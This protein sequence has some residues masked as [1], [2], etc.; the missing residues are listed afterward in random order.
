LTMRHGLS[1]SPEATVQ[2]HAAI[3]LI[4]PDMAAPLLAEE[5]RHRIGYAVGP[6]PLRS[7]THAAPGIESIHPIVALIVRAVLEN[8]SILMNLDEPQGVWAAQRLS[9]PERSLKGLN[10]LIR[11]RQLVPFSQFA[12][13]WE[14][15]D[16]LRQSGYPDDWV[17]GLLLITDAKKTPSVTTDD[18][19][20]YWRTLM[21]FAEIQQT[22][23]II[24]PLTK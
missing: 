1:A 12:D 2:A 11:A 4:A 18:A 22:V 17:R 7:H 19:R 13:R 20:A 8:P 9:L 14:L 16:H 10:L 21:Q 5:L 3:D 15:I 24:W 23:G 6:H